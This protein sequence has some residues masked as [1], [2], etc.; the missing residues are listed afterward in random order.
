MEPSSMQFPRG[1]VELQH[2]VEQFFYYEARLLDERRLR[3]WLELFTD[4]VKY[5]VRVREKVQRNPGNQSIGSAPT[6]LLYADD[7]DF[8]TLRVRRL[9]T[10]MAHAEKPPSITSHLIANVHIEEEADQVIVQS[11]FQVYQARLERDE[12]TFYGHRR[13]QLRRVDGSWRIAERIT[14]LDHI[15]LPRTL[16]I[17]F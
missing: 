5:S 9:E 17:F 8:L 14:T 6:Q 15:L 3:E 4:D 11:S 12:F 7:K 10:G 13:D 16:T 2:E 1:R